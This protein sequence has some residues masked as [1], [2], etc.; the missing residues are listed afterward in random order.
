MEKEI[1]KNFR[2][3]HGVKTYR[4]AWIVEYCL[5]GLGIS[6]AIFNIAVGIKEN[7]LLTQ[8]LLAVGWVIIGMIELSTIPLAGSFRLARGKNAVWAGAGLVGL[9]F[10]STFTVYEFNEIASEFMTRGARRT[11]VK[12]DKMEN[13]KSRVLETRNTQLAEENER[14]EIE[15]VKTLEYYS[16]LLSDAARDSEFPIYNAVETS[17]LSNLDKQ[18]ASVNEDLSELNLE[19]VDARR[20]AQVQLD[21]INSSRI[22]N[23]ESK[24]HNIELKIQT[25]A[26]DKRKRIDETSGGVFSSKQKKIEEI[27]ENSRAI[28]SEL[29][30]EIEAYDA[31]ILAIRLE[32]P[33]NPPEVERLVRRIEEARES[34]DSFKSERGQIQDVATKRM[35]TPEFEKK[36][37]ENGAFEN[38][39]YTQRQNA[40]SEEVREHK[41]RVDAIERNS[42]EQLDDLLDSTKQEADLYRERIV[43]EDE[44]QNIKTDILTNVEDAATKYEQVMY[45]RM[46]SWFS[47]EETTGFGKLPRKEDYNRA[48]RYIFAPVGVFFAVVSI[49][50]AYLGT[51]FMFEESRKY[52]PSVTME[53]L[54]GANRKLS[55]ENVTV[56]GKVDELTV[57]VENAEEIKADAV[58]GVLKQLEKSSEKLNAKIADEKDLKNL[59]SQQKKQ[60]ASNETDLL[61]AK[62]RVF[63]AIRSIPQT[64]TILDNS[65]SDKGEA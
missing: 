37:Q 1:I 53:E 51:G 56:R 20:G 36:V 55:D 42:Q 17:K 25:N 12:V 64:I 4:M 6:I 48:L 54:K 41:N 61:A 3:Q 39:V 50:L 57:R 19:L 11:A 9:V 58:R 34:I 45:Y 49:V 60:L 21:N 8:S 24:I 5:F 13:S 35:S 14:H 38:E 33:V 46:A 40:I 23:I 28:V 16:M 26:E 65:E 32:Q 44:I 29:Q 63:E 43:V 27:Q 52:D 31:E 59:I 10:L 15:N 47:G 62:K 18:I 7:D 30:I 2:F 22:R